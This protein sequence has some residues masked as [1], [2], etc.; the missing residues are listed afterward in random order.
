M[1]LNKKGLTNKFTSQT[2]RSLVLLIVGIM[3]VGACTP[4]SVSSGC[5]EFTSLTVGTSYVVSNVFTDSNVDM[6]V[7]DFQWG[8]GQWTSGG[9]ALVDNS[10]IAGGTSQEV[11]LNNVNLQFAFA[12]P[13]EGISLL[14]GEYGGNLNIEINGDFQNFENFADIDQT[15]IGGVD[16]SVTN[17]LGND[18]GTLELTGQI[19][20][21]A[22][23]GQE[24]WVDDVCH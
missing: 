7:T 11:N 6:T 1:F 15:N 24:L 8:N 21:F 10:G 2:I 20:L 12:P 16:I 18:Q 17:G 23:G 5:I 3:G 9:Q 14:F 19:E 4:S 13:S 22:I